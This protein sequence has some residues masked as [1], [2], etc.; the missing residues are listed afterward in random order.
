M[1]FRL[2]R[3]RALRLGNYA[4]LVFAAIAAIATSP[5][6][7]TLDATPPV[8]SPPKMGT[9]LTLSAS[10]EPNVMV[11]CGARTKT[12]RPIG[13]P[14]TWPGT[15]DYFVDPKCVVRG[16][17]ITGTCGGGLCSKC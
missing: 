7:W 3:S 8:P 10:H 11:E 9:T 1:N 12:L 4:A 15:A 5:A 2:E 14:A 13:G 16:I 17:S 6:R